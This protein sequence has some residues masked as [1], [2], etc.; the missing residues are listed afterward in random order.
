[1]HETPDL[2]GE[3]Y[4]EKE[5]D[6]DSTEPLKPGTRVRR[7][8][9]WRWGDQDTGGEG[10]VAGSTHW[11]AGWV[12]VR[13][14]TGE[15]YGYRWGIGGCF[16]LEVIP[17]QPVPEPPRLD[18]GLYCSCPSPTVQ[19][20]QTFAGAQFDFCTSCCKEWA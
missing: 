20:R 3:I 10:T 14:D 8:P 18:A 4:D 9:D 7:G 19:P 6:M 12:A 13:W 17:S 2:P 15:S 11:A 5:R 1:M 16:D